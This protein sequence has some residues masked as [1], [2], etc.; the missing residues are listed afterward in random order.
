MGN[1]KEA[2]LQLVDE[3][4]ERGRSVSEV[5]GSVGVSRSSYYRWRKGQGAGAKLVSDNGRGAPAH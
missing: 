4:R 3:H 1:Q 2:V 5:L